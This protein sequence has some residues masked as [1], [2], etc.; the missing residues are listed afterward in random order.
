ME[1]GDVAS[2]DQRAQMHAMSFC[3]V[4]AEVYRIE[5]SL[6]KGQTGYCRGVSK[7]SETGTAGVK[8]LSSMLASTTS[9][10]AKELV[11]QGLSER[12]G[13]VA[14]GKSTR[15]PWQDRSCGEAHRC[16]PVPMGFLRQSGGQMAEMGETHEASECDFIGR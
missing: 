10:R 9:G 15:T 2:P 6:T 4:R 14:F 12:I 13:M 5:C 16:V 8:A 1:N 11:K 3:S 7:N